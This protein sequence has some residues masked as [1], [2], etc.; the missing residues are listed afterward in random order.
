MQVAVFLNEEE[1][2]NLIDYVKNA[3]YSD[4]A[5]LLEKL[6]N[7][8]LIF[9]GEEQKEIQVDRLDERQKMANGEVL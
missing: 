5:K 6:E 1:I 2:N 4:D 9:S 3:G 7:A 8:K